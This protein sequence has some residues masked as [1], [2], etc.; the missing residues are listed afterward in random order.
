MLG[1]PAEQGEPPLPPSPPQRQ[2]LS[3][4]RVLLTAAG[5]RAR[6][7]Y[8]IIKLDLEPNRLLTVY[9]A[10]RQTCAILSP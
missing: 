7:I 5:C 9:S 2:T 6:W 4:L 10:C 8:V 3:Y 1:S